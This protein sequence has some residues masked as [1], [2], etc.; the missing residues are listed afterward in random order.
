M[1]RSRST[2][3]WP[4]SKERVMDRKVALVTGASSG[5]GAA[6]ARRLHEGGYLVHAGAR[7]VA[8]MQDLAQDGI[9]VVALDVADD[10]S[11][12]GVVGKILADHGRI[13]VLINNAGY[14]SYGSVEDVPLAEGR[15]QLEVNLFGLARLTQLVTP[16]MRAAG[17]GKIVNVSS[18]GGGTRVPAVAGGCPS[19]SRV[20]GFSGKRR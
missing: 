6:T 20:V 13:D 15:Y 14:G 1:A 12:T 17:A 18:I 19:K 5:I 10:S 8:R 11:M 7:R 4:P 2:S 3:P 9:S 16:Q